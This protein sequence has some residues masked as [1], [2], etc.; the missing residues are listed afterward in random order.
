MVP[1]EAQP[2]VDSQ[3]VRLQVYYPLVVVAALRPL[4]SSYVGRMVPVSESGM[5]A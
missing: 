4:S 2:V 5:A 3:V 1:Q